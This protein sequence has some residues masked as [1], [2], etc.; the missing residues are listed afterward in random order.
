VLVTLTGSGMPS[1]SDETVVAVREAFQR[2]PG[3]STERA[4]KRA[5]CTSEYNS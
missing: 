3:K 5:S 2:N 4:L 1:V